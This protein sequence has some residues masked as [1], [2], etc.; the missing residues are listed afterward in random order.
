VKNKYDFI[1]EV[2]ENKRLKPDQRERVLQLAA[3]EIGGEKSLDERISEL[4]K[5]LKDNGRKEENLLK[6]ESERSITS[7]IDKGLKKENKIPIHK[8]LDTKN[9]LLPFQN[10]Q[11]LKFLTH[12]FNGE[13]PAYEEFMQICKSEFKQAKDDFPNASTKLVGR[14]EVFAFKE[15]PEWYLRNGK[16]KKIYNTG[17]SKPVFIEWYK[18]SSNH[19]FNSSKWKKDMIIPFKDTIEV[20]A[21]TLW[22]LVEDQIDMAFGLAKVDFKFIKNEEL[23]NTAEFYTDVDMFQQAIFNIFCQ[24]KDIGERLFKFRVKIDFENQT[25]NGGKFKVLTITHVNSKPTKVADDP[26]L[27]KGDLKTIQG[28]LFGLCNYEILGEFPNSTFAKRIF[29]TD[30]RNEYQN[31]VKPNKSMPIENGVIEGFTHVLKFY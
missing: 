16:S 26:E 15:D 1:Q 17:W 2:L 23:I 4:E 31:Y 19:P 5:I 14:I 27:A 24:I 12:S 9:L 28:N 20:R 30:D 10:S 7:Y 13:K 11:G 25:I 6:I 22:K 18:S 3:R 21:G 8:P 29:L